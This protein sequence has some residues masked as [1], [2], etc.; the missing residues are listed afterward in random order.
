MKGV[1]YLLLFFPKDV[2]KKIHCHLVLRER[3]PHLFRGNAITHNDFMNDNTVFHKT[4]PLYVEAIYLRRVSSDYSDVYVNLTIK[5][6]V[7]KE[8]LLHWENVMHMYYQEKGIQ[9]KRDNVIR[10][11]T[12]CLTFK[13]H[14][15]RG[16]TDA[17]LI[18]WNTP[19]LCEVTR[20]NNFKMGE[21]LFDYRC[22]V[23]GIG[24]TREEAKMHFCIRL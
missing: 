14:F 6:Q 12:L 8:W 21:C 15:F 5:N 19:N 7:F 4:G 18:A 2:V 17:N 10:D 3:F 23:L 13:E 16:N 24:W 20:W 1:L 11:N 9:K 22:V